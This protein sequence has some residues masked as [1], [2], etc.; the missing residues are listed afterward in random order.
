MLKILLPTTF[1]TP[2]LAWPDNADLILTANSG[3]LVPSATTVSPMINGEIPR[4]AARRD[5]PRTSASA[6]AIKHN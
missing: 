3:E 2:M 1:P 6:P 4:A 5:A